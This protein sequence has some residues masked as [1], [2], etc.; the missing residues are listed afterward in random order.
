LTFVRAIVESHGGTATL[1]SELGSG[2][3]ATIVLPAEV[4]ANSTHER[5]AI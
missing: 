2:T 5:I 3:K 4:S 1:E